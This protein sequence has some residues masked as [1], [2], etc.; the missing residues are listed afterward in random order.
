[1][2]TPKNVDLSVIPTYN[3]C[4]V[5]VLPAVSKA[6]VRENSTGK[7]RGSKKK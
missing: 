7:R 6:E 2:I 1:M 5:A 3:W 4:M